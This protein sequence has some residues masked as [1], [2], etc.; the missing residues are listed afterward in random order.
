MAAAAAVVLILVGGGIWLSA[1]LRPTLVT[2]PPS[3]LAADSTLVFER[4][5]QEETVTWVAARAEPTPPH[6]TP[7]EA[8]P[9]SVSL[10]LAWLAGKDPAVGGDTTNVTVRYDGINGE[11]TEHHYVFHP[12]PR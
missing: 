6:A 10:R 8:P 5:G 2:S 7:N 11:P 3:G 4:R 9:D 1:W 12:A